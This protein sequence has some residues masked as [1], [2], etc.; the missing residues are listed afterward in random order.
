MIRYY[1]TQVWNLIRQEKLFSYIYI[2][3]TG[4][5]ITMVMVLSI[6]Y[7]IRIANIY[8]ETNRNR[9]L[10]ITSAKLTPKGEGWYNSSN[11]SYH[12]ASTCLFGL[13]NAEA[14]TL[15]HWTDGEDYVQ[16]EG[17]K[18]QWAVTVKYIDHAF[19]QVFPFHFID[20]K[21]ISESDMIS[22]S[23]V[24]VVAESL[25]KKLFGTTEATGKYVSYNFRPYRIIGVVKDASFI[26]HNSYAQLW[27]PYS[28]IPDYKKADSGTENGL[29]QYNA[30]V[31]ARPGQLEKC[32]EEI[33]SNFHKFAGVLP[34]NIELDMM[35][36]PDKQWESIFR[37]WSNIPP[38]IPAILLEYTLLFLILLTVP[39][40][41]L[42]GMADSRM[43]RRLAEM[44]IRRAFGAPN[45][46]LMLQI[47]NENFIFTL[48]GGLAGLIFSYLLILTGTEWIMQLNQQLNE[49]PP[50]GTKVA[51]S[52]GMLFNVPV[53][54]IALVVCFLLNLL[55]AIIP[56]WRASHRD[57]V[58]SL[59]AK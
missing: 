20:G 17:S 1:F 14:V 13:E 54:C 35:D 55:S 42:S 37:F 5:S 40:I 30:F 29:G 36:Q 3:G 19:W 27:I 2:I 32:K 53:F 39:A 38:D 18:E 15:S 31:L 7:Y 21:P 45:G 8:P 26:T 12:L 56:A 22:G 28:V 10:I 41:S 34:K 6:V 46:V 16:P 11:I 59:N 52:P 23:H 25:A 44:G 33:Q 50:E 51:L 58:Y 4:L 9:M 48:M 57:I 47:L 43:E 24:T 49:L